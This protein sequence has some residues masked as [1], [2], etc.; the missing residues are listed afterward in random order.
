MKKLILLAML[1]SGC[2]TVASVFPAED[3]AH[4]GN[5]HTLSY[6]TG[7]WAS[8]AYDANYVQGAKKACGG[9]HYTVVEKSTNPS[10]LKDVPGLKANWKYFWVVRCDKTAAE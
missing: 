10:T 1:V 4:T 6:G 2:E 8:G 7:E 9:E 5:I 3:V